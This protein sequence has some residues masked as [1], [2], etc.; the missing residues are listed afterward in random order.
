MPQL[1]APKVFGGIRGLFSALDATDDE[2]LKSIHFRQKAN[3]SLTDGG[4]AGTAQTE[5][6][7][8]RNDSAQNMR[9]VSVHV[10]TPVA[11]TGNGSNNATFTVAKRDS[12]G[13]NAATV[14]SLTTTVS[15]TQFA[16]T[17][18]TL[19][20]ANI[21]VP[22][23]GCLTLACSKG[24]TGVAVAAATSQVWLEVLLEPSD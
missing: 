8:Y 1:T 16:P 21:I 10:M 14:A 23:G 18:L 6:V 20:A 3:G 9:V 4:T 5:S 11:I 24:G 19:T 13:A 17:A 2:Y 7:F 15:I 12:A 22:S